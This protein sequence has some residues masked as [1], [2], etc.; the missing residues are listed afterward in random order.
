M[1]ALNDKIGIEERGGGETT[2]KYKY[3]E[4]RVAGES[5]NE[6]ENG[7]GMTT[8]PERER[9]WR[10]SES[11]RTR[12]R[13]FLFRKRQAVSWGTSEERKVGRL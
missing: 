1:T 9:E 4:R 5:E 11:D 3:W 10:E 12:A 13:N 8:G 6:N 2:S 7:V